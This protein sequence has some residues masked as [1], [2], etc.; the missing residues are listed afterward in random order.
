VS[1]SG[2]QGQCARSLVPLLCHSVWQHLCFSLRFEGDNLLICWRLV[3]GWKVK[4]LAKGVP[5]PP[6]RCAA[7][8]CWSCCTSGTRGY[9][10]GHTRSCSCQYHCLNKSHLPFVSDSAT[11]VQWHS[12]LSGVGQ[13]S[14]PWQLKSCILSLNL[15]LGL[16]C[17][18]E[19]IWEFT[20]PC[21]LYCNT[22]WAVTLSPWP[23]ADAGAPLWR[24]LLLPPL[25]G[26][27]A[28]LPPPFWL[29]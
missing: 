21:A 9:K 3:L 29:P 19:S 6:E 23:A 14:N 26:W 22:S 4:A 1:H 15:D 20:P 5:G 25:P 10:G 2:A 24:L 7:S 16:P 8:L 13:G 18:S 27:P 12:L 28:Y 11:S 17:E